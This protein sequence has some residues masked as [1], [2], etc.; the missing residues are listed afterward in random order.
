MPPIRGD[1]VVASDPS[2]IQQPAIHSAIRERKSCGLLRRWRRVRR[3][4]PAKPGLQHSDDDVFEISATQFSGDG[5]GVAGKQGLRVP[6]NT[7]KHLRYQN[8][9]MVYEAV[10]LKS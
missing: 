3:Q 10:T 4:V 9:Y 2:Q 1:A 8:P 7:L 5:L 6:N